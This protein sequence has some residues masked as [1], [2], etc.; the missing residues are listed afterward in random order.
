[1]NIK[2]TKHNAISYIIELFP[3]FEKY[4]DDYLEYWG[5][6][7]IKLISQT[8]YALST[9]IKGKLKS[10]DFKNLKEIFDLIEEFNIFGDEDV[11]YG[12]SIIF[13]ESLINSSGWNEEET[14]YSSY[15]HLLGKESKDFCREYDKMCNIPT[16][17]LWSSEEL[18]KYF[19]KKNV[20]KEIVICQDRVACPVCKHLSFYKS[21]FPGSNYFCQKCNWMDD[22]DQ[23]EDPELVKKENGISLNKAKSLWKN[24]QE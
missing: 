23:Y 11:Q 14:P 10:R 2:Y 5:H 24:N 6:D 15:I 8:F 12:A 13:L 3:E 18:K 1:M 16:P 21:M 22:K 7:G 19:S 17:G 9:F 20:P 4:L